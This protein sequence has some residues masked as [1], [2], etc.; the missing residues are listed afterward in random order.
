MKRVLFA[1]CLT[2][3][4]TAALAQ[5]RPST[6]TMSCGQAQSLVASRGALVLNTGQ[7]TYDRFVSN[8]GY[9]QRDEITLMTVAPTADTAQCPVGLRCIPS[10]VR[11][12]PD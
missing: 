3:L 5:G 6:M 12:F 7:F 10:D 11:R 4:A 1:V 2:G 9:C 8:Q